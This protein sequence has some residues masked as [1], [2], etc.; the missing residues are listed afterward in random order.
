MS[1]KSRL[2]VPCF[3][4]QDGLVSDRDS[5][6][7][8]SILGWEKNIL[9]WCSLK[10]SHQNQGLKMFMSTIGA[11]KNQDFPDLGGFSTSLFLLELGVGTPY[12]NPFRFGSPFLYH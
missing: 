7:S 11:K 10:I 3:G 6:S 1:L 9:A 8:P 4:T 5:W 2:M 12:E